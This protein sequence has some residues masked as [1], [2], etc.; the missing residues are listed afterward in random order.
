ML[1]QARIL[2]QYVRFQSHTD[3][4]SKWRVPA[5]MSMTPDQAFLFATRHGGLALRRPDLGILAPGAKADVLVWDTTNLAMTGYADPVAA[6]LLHANVG[7]I[8]S[9]LVDGV[10]RKRDGELL[11]PDLKGAKERFARS[12]RKVQAKALGVDRTEV[13][14]G[15]RFFS[16]A[17]IDVVP[18]VSVK[19]GR[20]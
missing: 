5:N 13:K 10:F 15:D 3:V 17:E 1:T 12:A 11:V 8:E 18:R 14:T 19:G 6:V 9:V 20:W 7:D 16:G 2:L 4:V